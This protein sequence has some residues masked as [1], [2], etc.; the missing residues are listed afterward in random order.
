LAFRRDRREAVFPVLDD[1]ANVRLWHKAD[2]P[3]PPVNVRFRR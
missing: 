2:I 3:M 1:I